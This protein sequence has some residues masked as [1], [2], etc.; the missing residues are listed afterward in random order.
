MKKILSIIAV[1]IL[2]LAGCQSVQYKDAANMSIS[3]VENLQVNLDVRNI[4]FLWDEAEGV[5]EVYIYRNGKLVETLPAGVK[6]YFVFREVP[7]EDVLYT[8]KVKKGDLV[9]EGITRTVH[10]DFDGNAGVTMLELGN[11]TGQEQMALTWFENNYVSADKGQV[12]KSETLKGITSDGASTINLD[13]YSTLWIA[14]EGRTE[15]PAEL[16]NEVVQGIRRLVAGG[17]KLYLTGDAHQLL[18]TMLRLPEEKM[19][20]AIDNS[21]VEGNGDWGLNCFM[22]K[23]LDY[24]ENAFFQGLVDAEGKLMLQNSSKRSNA[25]HLWS[26]GGASTMNSWNNAVYGYMYATISNDDNAQYGG[27]AYFEKYGCS[28]GVVLTG[29]IVTNILPGYQWIDGNAYQSNIEK[30]TQNILEEIRIVQ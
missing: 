2:L 24:R 3:S 17:G 19:P 15:W 7:N 8:F 13:R 11:P 30:L 21:I 22:H 29:T 26:I 27:L 10:I 16:D 9:S 25:N 14:I 28:D 12:V 1:A 20:Q 6:T 23:K 5:E 18:L 4:T